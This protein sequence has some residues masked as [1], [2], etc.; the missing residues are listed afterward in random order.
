M[1]VNNF[2][3]PWWVH[4]TAVTFQF[5]AVAP[6]IE[7]HSAMRPL[8]LML[9]HPPAAGVQRISPPFINWI[10]LRVDCVN[11]TRRYCQT[12]KGGS[13]ILWFSKAV[14]IDDWVFTTR[15][16]GS[17]HCHLAAR[18]GRR[19][20]SVGEA[21]FQKSADWRLLADK[22]KLWKECIW[23]ASP[24]E[25]RQISRLSLR[26]TFR[27]PCKYYSLTLQI[28]FPIAPTDTY[29]WRLKIQ[30]NTFLRVILTAALIGLFSSRTH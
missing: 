16:I 2:C 5:S 26:R 3:W 19:K 13:T 30:G 29:A 10:T 15:F 23:S 18:Y 22:P 1:H 17:G 25:F 9:P 6:I 20:L 21:Y 24:R 11:C 4:Y 27:Y 14:F 28:L 12:L 7:S 8:R